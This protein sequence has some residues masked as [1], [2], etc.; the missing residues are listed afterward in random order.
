MAG[1]G[2]RL[3]RPLGMGFVILDQ[4]L[5]DGYYLPIVLLVISPSFTRKLQMLG[6]KASN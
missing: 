3:H 1:C 6:R 2:L 5:F 4:V